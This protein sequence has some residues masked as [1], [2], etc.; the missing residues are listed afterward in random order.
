MAY[1]SCV[2]EIG[3]NVS[4]ETLVKNSC[5]RKRSIPLPLTVLTINEQ[6]RFPDIPLPI[7]GENIVDDPA[8][9]A[10]EEKTAAQFQQEIARRLGKTSHKEAFVLIHGN[11][12][13]FD[14]AVFMTA[15]FWH[16]LGRQGV[17][18]TYS[19]PAGG[20][21]NML[22]RYT[23]DTTSGAFTVYHLKQFLK[24][25]AAC[26]ELEKINIISHS[27]GTNIICNAIR[28][29]IIEARAAGQ[30]P[31]THYKIGN[32]ILAAPDID[33][34]VA[35]QRIAA[36]K[37]Y[38][39]VERLTVYVSQQDKVLGVADWL[40]RSERLGQV[41]IGDIS[42]AIRKRGE[43]VRRTD[44]IDADVKTGSGGH[45][46]FYTSPAVSSD[47]ILLLRDNCEPGTQ[48]GRPLLPIAKNYWKITDDYLK[49]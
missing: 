23:Y 14:D 32:V 30:N 49:K 43:K 35:L 33:Y 41:Q 18:I 10:Q 6:N 46:Y 19:W 21:G 15:G 12:A 5:I 42:D 31:L 34:S 16:F 8:S 1:G 11:F 40:F 4:W 39:G 26:P 37:F 28:E 25:L 29:L 20:P 44:I 17:P 38:T 9:Q 7:V 27:Q 22:H 13:S 36:E 47:L 45:Y 3:K 48:N 2:V 24:Y